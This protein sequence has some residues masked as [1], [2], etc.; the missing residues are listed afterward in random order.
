[1]AAFH[2]AGRSWLMRLAL[3]A[4][5]VLG[6]AQAVRAQKLEI[7]F[8][9]GLWGLAI[10][11][12]VGAAQ[13]ALDENDPEKEFPRR[14]VQGAAIGV[15]VGVAYGVADAYGVFKGGPLA[16]YEPGQNRLTLGAPLLTVSRDERGGS[17]A[18]EL[19][20]LRF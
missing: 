18:A 2:A 15:L 16:L 13:I 12:L 6:L 5:L 4:V 1:M 14:I 8:R 10:G 3:A 9:D 7:V 11:A 17:V 19:F 20:Q